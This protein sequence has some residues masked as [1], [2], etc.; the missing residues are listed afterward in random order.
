MSHPSL[1]FYMTVV[2]HVARGV[3]DNPDTLILIEPPATPICESA[4]LRL[5]T[6]EHRTY[7]HLG[8]FEVERTRVVDGD[9]FEFVLKRAIWDEEGLRGERHLLLAGR[10]SVADGW[11]LKRLAPK[12][13]T[14]WR[15]AVKGTTPV[16]RFLPPTPLSSSPTT[17]SHSASSLT[18][19][20]TIKSSEV[21]VRT[22]RGSV[23]ETEISEIPSLAEPRETLG[24]NIGE[25]T[26]GM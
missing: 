3:G 15:K 8:W 12:I 19:S 24:P 20:A 17:P 9:E 2:R 10:S 18:W 26:E 13:V 5:Y 23:D 7:T 21:S 16:P 14:M 1:G 4:K 22:T 11:N 6:R 25:S